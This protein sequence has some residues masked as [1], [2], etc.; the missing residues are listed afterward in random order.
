ML[1][2]LG[3]LPGWMFLVMREKHRRGAT[4]SGLGELL[5]VAAVGVGLTGAALVAWSIMSEVIAP[6][7]FVSINE[8]ASAGE[9]YLAAH[10][11]HVISTLALI[12]SV[13]CLLALLLAAFMYRSLHDAYKPGS[14]WE[15]A[16]SHT[17]QGKTVWLGIQLKEG[18]LVEGIL[19]SFD[20][21]EASEGN[22][23]VVLRPP[24]YVTVDDDRGI[25]QL[26]RL[27]IGSEHVQ[28]MS[29]IYV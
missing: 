9:T 10:P 28:Y 16:F 21:A 19:H 27:V 2:V 3:L 12:L 6:L 4:R 20:I 1:A 14:S 26:D 23:D 25:T 22:R 5:Q 8:F 7:G 24:I 13:A 11:R 29:A 15:Q 17:P 18:P